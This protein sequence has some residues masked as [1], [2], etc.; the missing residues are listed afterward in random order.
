MKIGYSAVL[1]LL[2]STTVAFAVEQEVE[3]EKRI[4]T[5]RREPGKKTA[6]EAI[7]ICREATR[8]EYLP[9]DTWIM[10]IDEFYFSSWTRADQ[11]NFLTSVYRWTDAAA[12]TALLEIA[13]KRELL[14]PWE[15]FLADLPD[16]QCPPDLRD[17]IR[18]GI[19]IG[20][21]QRYFRGRIEIGK[22]A[23]RDL[24]L[25]DTRS[26]RQT[27]FHT[28][29]PGSVDCDAWLFNADC[30]IMDK[31]GKKFLIFR[32]DPVYHCWFE[33]VESANHA[34]TAAETEME[35]RGPAEIICFQQLKSDGPRVKF[36]GTCAYFGAKKK[37][38]MKTD[39]VE[40]ALTRIE[41]SDASGKIVQT[42]R[43]DPNDN[44]AVWS[45]SCPHELADVNFDGR[46]D[47]LVHCGCGSNHGLRVFLR[48]TDGL[49]FVSDPVWSDILS[50]SRFLLHPEKRE[51]HSFRHSGGFP[52]GSV[53]AC[54]VGPDG[55]PV[56]I[57]SPL[58]D[59]LGLAGELDR[60]KDE[61]K[62]LIKESNMTL[63][64]WE[65]GRFREKFYQQLKTEKDSVLSGEMLILEYGDPGYHA[66][67]IGERS[68]FAAM[69]AEYGK[70]GSLDRLNATPETFRLVSELKKQLRKRKGKRDFTLR[71]GSRDFS[72]TVLTIRRADGLEEC[73]ELVLPAFA[74]DEVIIKLIRELRGSFQQSDSPGTAGKGR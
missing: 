41:I 33:S 21:V 68:A 42:I 67:S 17:R 16:A 34:E 39:C 1:A 50:G 35:E 65:Y 55:R 8:N 59:L 25:T 32:F 72:P 29:L 13:M 47:L 4:Q 36:Y 40:K 69:V 24:V 46:P 28:R 49:R 12:T 5:I 71:A 66:L 73:A 57:R 51:V 26:G 58:G 37:V 23:M 19:G 3:W 27:V 62:D 9:L 45:S 61:R 53:C 52:G 20:L 2:V 44:S 56:P 38:E 15:D 11:L 74:A 43:I 64:E 18:R 10:L 6:D 7:Q 60:L 63:G 22:N 54:R 48:S 31:S 30:L 14:T 70:P